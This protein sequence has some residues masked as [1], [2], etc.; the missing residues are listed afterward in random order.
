MTAKGTARRLLAKH[1]KRHAL[2][3]IADRLHDR[4]VRWAVTP[5]RETLRAAKYIAQATLWQS[6]LKHLKQA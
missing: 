2:E 1:G 3:L 6:V 4:E 5:R